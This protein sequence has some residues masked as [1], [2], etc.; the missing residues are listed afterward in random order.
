MGP[1]KLVLDSNILILA[2]NSRPLPSIHTLLSGHDELSISVITWMEVMAGAGPEREAGTRRF[3]A[4][5]LILE[6]TPAIAET[7]VRVRKTTRLK[8][9]DAIIYATA[10]AT[11]RTLLTLNSRDFPP[12][13][14]SILIPD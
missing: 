10:L 13:T 3:L 5:F 11:G 12:G 8:L 1:V 7:A 6:L 4:R 9:P 2:L 14:P